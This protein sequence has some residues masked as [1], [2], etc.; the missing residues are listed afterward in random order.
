MWRRI[1]VLETKSSGGENSWRRIGIVV[2]TNC[3]GDECSGDEYGIILV[4][5]PNC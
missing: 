4:V 1:I 3:S 5:E 2:E